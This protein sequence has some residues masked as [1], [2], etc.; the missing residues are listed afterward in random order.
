MKVGRLSLQKD[1]SYMTKLIDKAVQFTPVADIIVT[2]RARKVFSQE[3]LTKLTEAICTNIGLLHP[4][5]ILNNNTLLTGERRLRVITN[6]H[7]IGEKIQFVGNPIPLGTIPTIMV[8]NEF[9]ALDLLIAEDVENDARENFTWQEKAAIVA[10]IARLQ[11]IK[12]DAAKAAAALTLPIEELSEPSQLKERPRPSV[13]HMLDLMSNPE[14]VRISTAA[15]KQASMELHGKDTGGYLQKVQTNI[16]LH[17]ALQ[18]KELAKKLN[19]APT[20]KEA[21]KIL[22]REERLVKQGQLAHKQGK[23]LRHNR[24]TII[25]GDCLQE[26]KKLK[27]DSINI[28]LTDPIYGINADKF[29]VAKRD[30]GAHLYND[31]PEEFER[32]LPE[33][34]K[35]VSRI[36]KE[37]AH[38]YL[39]CDH[40]RFQQL[41]GYLE[42]NGSK[43][44]PWKVQSFPIHY[45]KVNGA[46]CPVPG[47]SFR[48]TVEYIIFAWRGGKQ[49]NHQLDS[50]F[51]VSTKRTEIHGA[52]KEPSALKILLN[53]SCYPGDSVLDFMAGSGSTVVACDELKLKCTAIEIDASA[54]GRILERVKSVD[55]PAKETLE[56]PLL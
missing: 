49:S 40:S 28:C 29:G 54:Y 50:H 39:F 43:N 35:E 53:N 34:I 21:S 46:R 2:D 10:N 56:E 13:G 30:L 42:T 37:A 41:K 52:A 33:A 15:A 32:I 36:L 11:Q 8:D 17:E 3:G 4:I 45:I 18:D 22:Q 44:N 7:E 12:L 38:L 27:S 51:E 48:K 23:E 24:H 9:D 1:T 55:K 6:L 20:Q 16:K 47:F 5:I 19:K 31:S 14:K 25:N 26:L